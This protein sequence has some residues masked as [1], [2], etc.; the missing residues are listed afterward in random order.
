[1]ENKSHLKKILWGIGIFILIISGIILYARF[2]GTSGLYVK[3]YKVTNSSIP[4]SFY[5]TKIVQISDI[6]YGRTI[7]K[8]ELQNMVDKV[9]QLK[10]DIIVLT[11]DL[12]DKDTMLTDKM[13]TVISDILKQLNATIGKY[14]ITGNHDYKFD[15]WATIISDSGFMNLNDRYDIIYNNSTKPIFLGGLSTNTYQKEKTLE[16]KIKVMNDY[17]ATRTEENQNSFPDYKILIMHEPD[18]VEEVNPENYDLILA[19][20]SH[21]GQVKLP[22]IG[23]V[24]L[25]NGAKKYHKNYY[26]LNGT[27]FYISSG[28]GT[29]RYNFRLFNRPSINLY[30]L[31]DH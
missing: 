30:R 1:M 31:V 21:D 14:A 19:G 4:D 26:N 17:F 25:P 5:G 29:S 18:Y 24:I 13:A 8:Q 16:E 22:G 23:A 6:H 27:D 9:N 10:P 7:K 2:I 15:K 28:I 11:G 3:E 20:H 12:I